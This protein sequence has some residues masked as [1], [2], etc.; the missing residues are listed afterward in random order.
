MRATPRRN[1]KHRLNDTIEP[2]IVVDRS[3]INL[4]RKSPLKKKFPDPNS[5]V[6]STNG[7]RIVA[8]GFSSLGLGNDSETHSALPFHS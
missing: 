7:S 4:P 3:N 1:S 5:G 2:R 8:G 6:K